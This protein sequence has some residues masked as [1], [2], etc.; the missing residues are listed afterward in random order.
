MICKFNEL[1]LE[2]E[3]KEISYI[4]D[5]DFGYLKISKAYGK[6][7]ITI[8]NNSSPP[9]NSAWN[10]KPKVSK[11][12]IDSDQYIE[13]YDRLKEIFFKFNYNLYHLKDHK[14]IIV[15]SPMTDMQVK[16]K[17]KKNSKL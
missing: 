1:N 17:L 12:L 2:N 14:N 10:R 11:S 6:I 15:L 16:R 5:D 8:L 4:I 9:S 13:F 3:I 7:Y